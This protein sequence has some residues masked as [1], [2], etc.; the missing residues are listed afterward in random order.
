MRVNR[1]GQITIPVDLRKKYGITEGDEVDVIEVGGTLTIVHRESGETR[2]QRLVRRMRGAAS[3][4]M[5]T[6]ELMRLL[7]GDDW[8]SGIVT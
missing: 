5:S 6:D 2:G 7:R 3:T 1:R 8:G 4:T